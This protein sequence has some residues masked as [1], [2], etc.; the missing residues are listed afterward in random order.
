MGVKHGS[1]IGDQSWRALLTVV[2]SIGALT[3]V[4]ASAQEPKL[5]ATLDLTPPGIQPLDGES[6]V[7]AS[8]YGE[9]TGTP[10]PNDPIRMCETEYQTM[11]K[12]AMTV[13]D[14]ARFARLMG[15]VP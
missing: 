7:S 14:A 2:L 10:P 11:D 13:E 1:R 6:V 9:C 8:V 3:G 4:R 15:N 5:K 12:R